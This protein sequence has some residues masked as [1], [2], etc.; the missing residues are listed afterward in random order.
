[1]ETS[2]R[3]KF[4][5]KA[6]MASMASMASI[7][8][9]G[10]IKPYLESTLPISPEKPVQ[11]NSF[12]S[13]P[14]KSKRDLVMQV[15]D[16]STKPNYIPAGFFMHFGVKG[17]AAVKAHLEYFR[18]TNMDFVKIQYDEKGLPRNDQIKTAKDWAKIP[19]LTE[20]WFAPHLYLL[21]EIIKEAKK[22]ALIIQTLYGPFMHA[23]MVVPLNLLLEHIKEDPDSVVRG[24][25]NVTLSLLHFVNAAARLGVDGFYNCT[26]GGETNRIPDIPLF[27]HIVKNYDMILFKEIS[28]LVPCNILHICDYEGPYQDFSLRFKDYAGEIINIPGAADNKPLSLS[29]A[30]EIFNRPIMGGLD[31]HGVITTGSTEDVKKATME[32]LKDAPDHVILG[33]NCTVDKKTTPFENIKTAI[34]TAHNFRM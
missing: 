27:N 2:S 31:R 23:K 13:P 9:L 21:K 30:A 1:M 28:Q 29:S 10:G 20:E 33:A 15:L 8:A 6:S 14:G 22:E 5:V 11:K 26:Q 7:T 34:E 17:D 3:R 12:T 16:M 4:I 18:A 32:L 25:E 19:I 24:M